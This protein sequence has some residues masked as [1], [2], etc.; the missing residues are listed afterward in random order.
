[1]EA[2]TGQMTII[3]QPDPTNLRTAKISPRKGAELFY[4]LLLRTL[5]AQIGEERVEGA[6][7]VAPSRKGMLER[8]TSDEN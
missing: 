7:D 5:T 6:L 3:H 4:G 1:M 2:G 8:T